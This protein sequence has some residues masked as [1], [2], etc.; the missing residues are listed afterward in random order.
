MDQ[1]HKTIYI[2]LV[3]CFTVVFQG[4]SRSYP[5]LDWSELTPLCKQQALNATALLTSEKELAKIEELDAAL[6]KPIAGLTIFLESQ[7]PTFDSRNLKPRYWLRVEDYSST[8]I[9]SQRATEYSSV[10]TYERIARASGGDSFI[11]SKTTVRLWAIA[12]GKRVY[13][14]TTDTNLFGLIEMPVKLR[15]TIGMLP[16]R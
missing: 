4:C 11:V 15:K 8:A 1:T 10:D 16:E 2:T 6:Y 13:A 7:T 5:Q 12:R 14:L 9:A 3:L